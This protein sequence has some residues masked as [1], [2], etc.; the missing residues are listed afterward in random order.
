VFETV[1]MPAIPEKEAALLGVSPTSLSESDLVREL[2]QLHRTRHETS[3][4][5][6]ADALQEHSERTHK[7]EGEYLR[8]HPERDVDP[9]RTRAGA[10]ER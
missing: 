6:S 9:A 8:R 4:H 3:L 2:Q 5:G 1:T 7:L 10:R